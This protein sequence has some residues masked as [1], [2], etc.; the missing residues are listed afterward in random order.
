MRIF[1]TSGPLPTE[2]HNPSLFGMLIATLI[3][4][5]FSIALITATVYACAWVLKHFEII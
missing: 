4:G 2:V 5:V 3:A 1:N